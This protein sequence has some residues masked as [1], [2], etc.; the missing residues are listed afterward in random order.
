MREGRRK[1]AYNFSFPVV[2]SAAV[3]RREGGRTFL[4]VPW[5]RPKLRAAADAQRVDAVG[6][7]IAAARIRHTPPVT[8]C[9]DVD[10]TLAP[11]TLK[12]TNNN[13]IYHHHHHRHLRHCHQFI[14]C[15]S[16]SYTRN[17]IN[18]CNY[19]ITLY[20]TVLN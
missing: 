5:L 13:I 14:V 12:T 18:C 1:S 19:N 10:R 8:R 3:G 4:Q 16:Q 20:T 7:S 11:S 6:I 2:L 9:P 17:F 15:Y